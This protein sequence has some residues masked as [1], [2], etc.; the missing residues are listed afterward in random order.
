LLLLAVVVDVLGIGQW[1]WPMLQVARL[2]VVAVVLDVAPA[3]VGVV[4]AS[5]K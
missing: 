3:P 2:L 4:T 5:H 1:R